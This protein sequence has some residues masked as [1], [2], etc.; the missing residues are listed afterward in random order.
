MP[1]ELVRKRGRR[2][3]KADKD[4]GYNRPPAATEPEVLPL[5]EPEAGP[6]SVPYQPDQPGQPGF[7]G[8]I[9]PAAPFGYVD[10]DIKAYFKTVDEKLR[11]WEEIG[12][13]P[14]ESGES[15]LEGD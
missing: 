5:D 6:S 15:E 4:D 2:A 1:K 7:P 8:G 3:K 13:A 14:G 9:D 11:E 12:L 10:P